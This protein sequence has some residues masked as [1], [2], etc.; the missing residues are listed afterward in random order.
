MIMFFIAQNRDVHMLLAVNCKKKRA[1]KKPLDQIH[2]K[3][4]LDWLA[5]AKIDFDHP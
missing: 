5:T 3:I 4:S 1:L 2:K